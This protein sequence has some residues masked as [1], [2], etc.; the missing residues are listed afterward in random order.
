MLAHVLLGSRPSRELIYQALHFLVEA[1]MLE[2]VCLHENSLGISQK[3]FR[4]KD[5]AHRVRRI[6]QIDML[7]QNLTHRLLHA[8]QIL[9]EIPIERLLGLLVEFLIFLQQSLLRPEKVPR[10]ASAGDSLLST[11]AGGPLRRDSTDLLHNLGSWIYLIDDREEAR[12][13]RLVAWHHL[14][15]IDEVLPLRC[16]QERQLVHIM[17][18]PE[19]IHLES[20]LL[21]LECLQQLVDRNVRELHVRLWASVG[22]ALRVPGALVQV[23][24]VGGSRVVLGLACIGGPLRVLAVLRGHAVLDS[25]FGFG[26][27]GAGGAAAGGDDALHAATLAR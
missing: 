13:L 16:A 21:E 17:T 18:V 7:G 6:L 19:I 12:D 2:S 5:L 10:P 1:L 24:V 4:R 23:A 8:L 22:S 20:V 9:Q 14:E 11:F 3:L 27:L 15:L 26:V 25:E